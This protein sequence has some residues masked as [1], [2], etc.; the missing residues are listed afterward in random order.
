MQEI[1]TSFSPRFFYRKMGKGPVAV[2]LH[3]FPESGTLWRNIWTGLSGGY[4]LI[5][6]DLPGAGDS[7]LSGSASIAQMAAG[8]KDIL[9]K[10]Q[11]EKAVIIGHSMGGYVALAF[12]DMFPGSVAGLTLVHSTTAADDEEKKKTRQ[13]VI[14]FVQ[15]GNKTAFLEQMVPG[16][17]A[18]EYAAKERQKVQEQVDSAL[19]MSTEGL[20]NFY[21]AMMERPERTAVLKNARYPVQWIIGAKD[22]LMAP[23]KLIGFAYTAQVNFIAYYTDCGHMS[24]VEMPDELEN[25]INEF[26]NYCYRNELPEA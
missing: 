9:D 15:K 26:L 16:L 5:V 23:S 2:L 6:P 11:I 19:L 22:A 4:T 10:E 1:S 13:K 24:M 21:K 12:A 7:T 25:D 20:V 18:Q 3:G 14:D 8:V 17:F